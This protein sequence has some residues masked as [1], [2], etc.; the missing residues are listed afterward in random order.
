MTESPYRPASG[1]VEMIGITKRFGDVLANDRL[2]F[3][4]QWGEVHALLGEN[5]AGKTTLMSILSGLYRADAGQVRLR[6]NPAQIH[7]PRDAIEHGIGMVHQ[8]FMLIKPFTVAENMVFGLKSPREPWLDLDGVAERVA[9]LSNRYGLAV[10]PRARIQDLSVGA[11]QRVEIIKALYRG[12]DI[13]VLDEPTSVLTPQEAEELFKILRELAGQSHTVIFI[14]HKLDEVIAVADRITVLRDGRRIATVG[15]A[16][17]DK[18][19]LARMMVGREVLFRLEK[20]ST[21]PGPEILAIKDLW[22][23]GADGRPALRG[24]SFSLRAGEIL[25]VA[26]VDGNGQGE[27]AQVIMGTRRATAGH[28]YLDG[29]EVTHAS[30]KERLMLGVGYIPEDRNA[31]GLIGSF[32]VGENTILN[33]HFSPPYA[34][35]IMLDR[36]AMVADAERLI[37]EFDV[38]TAGHGERAARLSGGNL[39]KLVLARE[40]HRDPRALIA[41]QPT[42]GLD[43]GATEYVRRRLLEQRERGRA[44]LLISADLEEVLTLSDRILVVYEGAMTGLLDAKDVE[45]GKLGLMMA[46]T[47]QPVAI[48]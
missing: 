24:L 17:T 13:L 33:T 6:G 21:T 7:S 38:K 23:H 42:R 27:L 11:Q 19:D 10:N 41:A 20:S 12:A 32:S 47:K 31:V 5:G 37:R 34:R 1:I 8:H 45:I 22:A 43:V 3:S 36:R 48:H 25:G 29:K 30:P 39:Q 16:E 46:G 40:V 26:G 4:A 18:A 35:G 15:K 28:I 2:D 44:I 14:T 9:E